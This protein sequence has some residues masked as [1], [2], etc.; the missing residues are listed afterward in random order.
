MKSEHLTEWALKHSTDS[1]ETA[2]IAFYRDFSVEPTPD[3]KIAF[4]TGR[5][6][7]IGQSLSILQETKVATPRVLCEK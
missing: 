5:L 4:F 6:L 2:W 3:I 7:G 1:S